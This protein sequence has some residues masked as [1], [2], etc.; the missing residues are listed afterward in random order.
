MREIPILY[1]TAMIK[2][3]LAGRKTM[4]RRT[5]KLDQ[6][7]ANPDQWKVHYTGEFWKPSAH[8]PGMPTFWVMFEHKETRERVSIKCPYGG[9]GDVLWARESF[10]IEKYFNGLRDECFPI[11]KANYDG[12][13]AWNWKPSI[14]MPKDA[15]RIW[16]EVINVR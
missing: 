5:T 10:Q 15:A 6:I 8:K 4:T 12:P 1:S 11:Y 16:D 3:K 14:H 13:V 7:N 2:A 9:V